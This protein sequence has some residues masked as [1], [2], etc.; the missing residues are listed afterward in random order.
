MIKNEI[1]FILPSN[2]DGGGNRWSYALASML[3]EKNKELKINFHYPEFKNLSNIYKLNKLVNIKV[4]KSKFKSKFL[5]Y[6]FFI[7][8]LKKT[9][10]KKSTII[11]SDPILSI[12]MFLFNKNLVIRNVA[13]DDYNL[14]NFSFYR[15]FGILPIY[16]ILT[17]ISFFYKNVNFVFNS[18]FTYSRIFLYTK[19]PMQINNIENKIIHPMID[20]IYLENKKNIF[21]KR[22][23]SI[24]I[25]PRKHSNKGFDLIHKIKNSPEIKNL[26]LNKIYLIFNKNESFKYFSDKD[27]TILHPKS[28]QDIINILDKSYCFIST[29]FSEGFGLPPLEAM[30][31]GCVPIV[32]DAGGTSSYCFNGYNSLVCKKNDSYSL[33]QSIIKLFNNQELHNELSFNGI[34]TSKNFNQNYVSNIWYD[35]IFNKITQTKVKKNKSIINFLYSKFNNLYLI[36]K[37][38]DFEIRLNILFE[39][40]F[41]PFLLLYNYLHLMFGITSKNSDA[42]LRVKSTDT[43]NICL[44][45]WS[46]YENTRYKKLKN[47]FFYKCG[48][49]NQIIKL[50]SEKY[51][52]NKY[53]YLTLDK[54]LD[55]KNKISNIKN[56]DIFKKNNFKIVYTN[57]DYLDF[58]SYSDFFLNKINKKNNDILLFMNSSVS[59]DFNVPI[60]DNY[61]DYF[62]KNL[63]VGLFGISS[64]SKKYQSIIVNNFN[65]HIQSL[66]FITTTNILHEVIKINN[67]IFPGLNSTKKNKYSL[68]LNGE[69]KL[70]EIV[71]KLGYKIAV[72]N[73]YGKVNK[74]GNKGFLKNRSSWPNNQNDMRLNSNYPSQTNIIL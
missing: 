13:S 73:E 19:L 7:F 36:Y 3:I 12:F 32:I 40:I 74:F 61:V 9:I 28:D 38:C 70:S 55:N 62:N 2:N 59:T 26:N 41:F 39:I 15:Y 31:R 47:G 66:F 43:I 37:G 69:I 64:N 72:I 16:K 65:P 34:N 22:E 24:V 68:I 46:E 48:L 44:Q 49:S 35:Y 18:A 25:F 58:S 51:N 52:T 17:Y 27:Y 45:D 67:N 53:L 29:S 50:Y 1:N 21:T 30:S 63:D 8:F 11:I 14:Y 33:L 4:F 42:K 5:V 23:K 57:N 54:N 20:D 71:L 6:I 10:S 56:I 60:I